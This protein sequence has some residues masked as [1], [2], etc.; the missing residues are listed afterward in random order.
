MAAIRDEHGLVLP[1]LNLGGGFGVPYT[2]GDPEPDPP[3]FAAPIRAAVADACAAARLP[4]P[5]ITVEPG[6]AIVARAGSLCTG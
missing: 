2:A 3:G 1:Q 5:R 6:R 4:V